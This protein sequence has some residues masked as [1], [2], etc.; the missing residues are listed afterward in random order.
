MTRIR[1]ILHQQ[2]EKYREDAAHNDLAYRPTRAML[3]CG[4][5]SPNNGCWIEVAYHMLPY[6]HCDLVVPKGSL[7]KRIE[8]G[9]KPKG[10]KVGSRGQKKG[11]KKAAPKKRKKGYY[12][13]S[14]DDDDHDSDADF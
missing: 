1:V 13:N 7:S 11:R 8:V 5:D 9:E 6:G 3:D 10:K 14:D 12:S 2:Q 4:G